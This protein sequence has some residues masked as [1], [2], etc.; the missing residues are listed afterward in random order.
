M[1]RLLK[2]IC[3]YTITTIL[4]FIIFSGNSFAE[5]LENVLQSLER[6]ENDVQDLQ[7]EVYRDKQ[8]DVN[9]D[10]N[11]TGNNFSVLDIRIRDIE[12]QIREYGQEVTHLNSDAPTPYQFKR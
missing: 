9:N 8:T 11:A 6:I 1:I 12:N 5:D 3:K 2:Y 10:N 4:F 7:K